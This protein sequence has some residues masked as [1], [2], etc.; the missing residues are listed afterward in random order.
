MKHVRLSWAVTSKTAPRTFEFCYDFVAREAM[1]GE[2]T[3]QLKQEHQS[4]INKIS[5]VNSKLKTDGETWNFPFLF[6]MET[7]YLCISL[8]CKTV[9]LLISFSNSFQVD[10]IILANCK[11]VNRL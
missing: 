1:T 7:H 9:T 2:K 4:L 10:S 6:N 8:L 5:E 11:S 3:K